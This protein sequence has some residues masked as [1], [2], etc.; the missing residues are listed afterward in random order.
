MELRA[1]GQTGLH[2]SPLGLGTVKLGRNQGVKYPHGFELPTDQQ[3]QYLL[4]LSQELGLNLLDTA[5]AYGHS[6]QRLG[7]L[8]TNR[9]RWVIV[10][11][12][13]EQF[14]AGQSQFDFSATAI[15]SS[16][17]QS[18]RRLRTDWLDVVLLHS[19]GHDLEILQGEALPTLRQL[20]QQGWIRAVGIS[21][22]TVEGGL[23]AVDC[24]DV[25]MVTHNPSYQQERAVIA[26]AQQRQRGVLIKKALLSGHLSQFTDNPIAHCFKC[27]FAEPGV[28]S[29]II[30]TLNPQHLQHNV[31]TLQRVLSELAVAR[32]YA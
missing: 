10:T 22:K 20:Q 8:L 27:V 9:Q 24:C 11:K 19:H 31:A 28:S 2:V 14:H 7:E 6:E 23:H 3:A 4:A 15:R 25:V 13:G 29:A 5:P 1:L 17:E 18:L 32:G 16:V 30:G 26:A 21:S 12:V